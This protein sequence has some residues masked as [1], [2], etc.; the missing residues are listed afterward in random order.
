MTCPLCETV[1]G[2]LLIERKHYRIIRAEDPDYPGFCRIIW[3]DHVAEMSDLSATHQ[4]ELMSAVFAVERT[5]R[6]LYAPDKINLASLGNMVPHVHWHVIA[7]KRGD[8]HFPQPVWAPPQRE[9]D[10][11]WPVVS[12]EKLREAIAHEL[13]V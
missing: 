3:R 2:V 7:R 13:G 11:I 12:D 8:R 10:V 4:H 5:V 1:G 6:A 9:G